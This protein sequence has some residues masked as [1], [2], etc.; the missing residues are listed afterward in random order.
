MCYQRSVVNGGRGRTYTKLYHP[1]RKLCK[2]N[3]LSVCLQDATKLSFAI[4]EQGTGFLFANYFLKMIVVKHRCF[5]DW[6][7]LLALRTCSLYLNLI[8]TYSVFVP[9][10]VLV[11]FAHQSFSQS[12]A[13]INHHRQSRY[14]ADALFHDAGQTS[15]IN[16][17][18][19]HPF[20]QLNPLQS[21]ILRLSL[22]KVA[23]Q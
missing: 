10:F 1:S 21:L 3:A 5:I 23:L 16:V 20:P 7:T 2:S 15:T 6:T 12:T 14:A 18:K 8:K 4:A 19:T 11:L 13:C 22:I 9:M 17:R